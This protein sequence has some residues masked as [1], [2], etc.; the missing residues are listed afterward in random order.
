[1][2]NII[3]KDKKL[4]VKEYKNQRVVTVWDISEVHN[5]EVKRINELFNRN[6]ERFFEK[7]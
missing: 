7:L 5:K 2:S 6:K 4:L 1:M 3:I